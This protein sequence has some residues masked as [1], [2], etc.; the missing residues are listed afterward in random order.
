[1]NCIIEE[2]P[3][4]PEVTYDGDKEDEED[5]EDHDE[6]KDDSAKGSF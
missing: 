6:D 5:L 3:H 4:I 1:M 2:K